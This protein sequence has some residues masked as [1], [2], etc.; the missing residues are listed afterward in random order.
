M[1][2][3]CIVI[4]AICCATVLLAGCKKHKSENF[5]GIAERPSWSITEDYDYSSSMTA[6]VKVDLRPTVGTDYG[7]MLDNDTDGLLA[8]FCDGE[9]IGVASSDNGLFYLYIIP[10]TEANATNRFHLRYYSEVLHNL[11]RSNEE[12]D[13]C[14]D[15]RLGSVSAPL[16][17]T[18]SL[19]MQ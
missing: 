18:F 1:K 19:L 16:T 13:F 6:I 8:A 3:N 7:D 14:S 17:P 4:I 2:N 12:Y 15:A 11:F 9:C 10:P 5:I